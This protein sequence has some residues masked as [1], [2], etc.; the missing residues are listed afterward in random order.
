VKKDKDGY[1]YF[2]SRK[3]EMI[4]T[5]GYRVSPTEVEEVLIEI[6]SI[7][8]AVVF[9][10]ELDNSEQIIVAVVETDTIAIDEKAVMQECRKLLPRYMVPH[11]IHFE[12]AFKKTA[13]G[14]IDRSL[15]K[16]KWLSKRNHHAA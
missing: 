16:Q 13:N 15:I 3:D 7:N 6:P 14:K 10:K 12:E 8:N 2:L 1:L 5:S 11:E 4:K 9:G